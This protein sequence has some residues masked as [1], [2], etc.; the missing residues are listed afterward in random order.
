LLRFIL[1]RETRATADDD[2]AEGST[3]HIAAAV[4]TADATA[5]GGDGAGAGAQRSKRDR[6]GNFDKRKKGANKGRRWNKVHDDLNL[7]WRLAA[8]RTCEFGAE[9]VPIPSLERL[10]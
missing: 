10:H 6:G 2:A 3:N 9:C 5:G 7:C 4:E 8:G 1:R